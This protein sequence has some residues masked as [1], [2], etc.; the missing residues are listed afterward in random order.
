MKK[1]IVAQF[2]K[3]CAGTAYTVLNVCFS[4]GLLG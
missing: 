2:P 4:G 3:G 1:I